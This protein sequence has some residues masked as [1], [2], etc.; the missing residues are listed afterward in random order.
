MALQDAIANIQ[1]KALALSGI[2]EAPDYAVESINQLPFVI[3]YPASGNVIIPSAG[4]KKG[5]HTVITEFHF[6]R[7]ILNKSIEQA[8][9]Y[10]DLFANSLGNDPTLSGN[11]DT[12]NR[13]NYTFGF[14]AW[15][16]ETNVHIGWRFELVDLKIEDSLS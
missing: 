8:M 7:A 14:L 3:T 11:V 2:K 9:P 13:I 16:G 6:N 4:W 10:F 1:S 15:D 5:L 12:I